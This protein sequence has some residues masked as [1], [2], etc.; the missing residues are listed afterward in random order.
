MSLIQV[1]IDNGF[2]EMGSEKGILIVHPKGVINH[3]VLQRVMQEM[4]ENGYESQGKINFN[5]PIV[6]KKKEKLD[7]TELTVKLFALSGRY[8]IYLK[9][10]TFVNE[11]DIENGEVSVGFEYK[12]KSVEKRFDIDMLCSMEKD[13]LLGWLEE[14]LQKIDSVIEAEKFD[15]DGKHDI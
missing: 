6:M 9:V 11:N 15:V 2:I 14:Q 1:G 10:E 5:Q 4:A 8:G 7:L 12:G 13:Y 3:T